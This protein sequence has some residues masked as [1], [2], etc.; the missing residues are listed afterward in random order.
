MRDT[1]RGLALIGRE[2]E[3]LIVVTDLERG[4]TCLLNLAE[5]ALG[6]EWE[7]LVSGCRMVE[8]EINVREN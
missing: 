2:T 3:M 4:E 5:K 1:Y 6:I 7:R 8:V